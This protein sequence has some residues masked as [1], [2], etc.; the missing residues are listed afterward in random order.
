MS[1]DGFFPEQA[2]EN[3]HIN[4]QDPHDFLS[5]SNL[6]WRLGKISFQSLKTLLRWMFKKLSWH[7][8]YVQVQAVLFFSRRRRNGS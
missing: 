2:Y 1:E 5:S 8:H 4:W 3:K 7:G 6:A